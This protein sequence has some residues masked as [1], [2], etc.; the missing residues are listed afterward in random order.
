MVLKRSEAIMSESPIMSQENVEKAERE[1]RES[2]ALA[3]AKQ[4]QDVG[5]VSAPN[6]ETENLYQD[7]SD[8]TQTPS[9]VAVDAES[10]EDEG[11]FDG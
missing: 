9:E 11:E 7:P 2:R 4:D 5:E 1:M 10:L 3:K 6:S 8:K